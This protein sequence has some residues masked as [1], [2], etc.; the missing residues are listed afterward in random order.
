MY[1]KFE[2]ENYF[3]RNLQPTI[4]DLSNYFSWMT[5][6]AQNRFIEGVRKEFS[7]EELKF[8]IT[9]KNSSLDAILFGI[10]DK[11]NGE[12]VGNVKLEPIIEKNYAWM[13]ILIGQ[14]AYRGI[15]VGFEVITSIIDFSKE[16]LYLNHI[17]LG[18]NR[19]NTPALNLYRKLGFVEILSNK[20]E[21]DAVQMKYV[22]V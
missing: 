6:V 15:G 22:L 1:G 4:D 7:I 13:G 18:V 11:T 10:F 19:K 12:H 16:V 17:C 9:E 2:S 14:P 21:S 20:M 5:D 8:Y 3:L